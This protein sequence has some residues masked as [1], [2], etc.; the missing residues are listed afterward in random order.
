MRRSLWTP[1]LIGSIGFRVSHSKGFVCD[2]R[3][4]VIRHW[5]ELAHALKPKEEELHNTLHP[6]VEAVISSKRILLFRAMLQD[7]GFEGTDELIFNMMSGFPVV[8]DFPKTG[9]FPPSHSP[10]SFTQED[11][12]RR[13]RRAAS[14]LE[15]VP[16]SSGDA[17]LDA[18]VWNT[19]TEEVAKRWL[20]G[21]YTADELNTLVG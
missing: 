12:W 10:T 5:R 6:D 2:Y 1:H 3:A 21:P 8:G 11:F 18:T 14:E 19:T 4:N 7:I 13:A 15:A 17:K 9:V 20:D 16:G